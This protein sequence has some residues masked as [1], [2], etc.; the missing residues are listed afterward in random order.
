[1]RKVLIIRNDRFGEFLL[2]IPVFRAVKETWPDVELT[3]GVHPGVLELTRAVPY[4]DK[5]I[6]FP[7]GRLSLFHQVGLIWQ[8]RRE[9]YDAAVVLNPSATA[10]ELINCAGIPL[11]VGYACKHAFFL[12]RTM[13][14]QKHQGLKHE[15]ENNL[16]LARLLGCST[17]NHSLVLSIPPDVDKSISAKFGLCGGETYVAVHPWTSDPVKQ[18][19]LAN[20][21]RLVKL[22]LYNIFKGQIYYRARGG[23]CATK[24][25]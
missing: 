18:W 6:V 5:A 16:D 15:V 8:L 20:F 25:G 1:M 10:H 9:H 22:L 3:V 19:P 2:N 24:T 17:Q 4:I 12:N 7:T 11:R 23:E 21:E 14:D 13:P